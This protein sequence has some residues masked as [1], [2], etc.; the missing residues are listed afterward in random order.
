MQQEQF[1]LIFAKEED[2]AVELEPTATHQGPRCI[3]VKQADT[4]TK[5]IGWGFR[6]LRV[7]DGIQPEYLLVLTELALN[8][9]H[10]LQKGDFWHQYKFCNLKT[11]HH[12]SLEKETW[13][14]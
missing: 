11:I 5:V 14:G 7:S 2:R 12:M 3:F 4:S 1:C 10:I 6:E 13:D 8:G 9:H